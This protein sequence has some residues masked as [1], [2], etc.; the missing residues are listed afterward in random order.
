MAS[1]RAGSPSGPDSTSPI[2]SASPATNALNRFEKK[3]KKQRGV[4]RHQEGL[5]V[6]GQESAA[7]K[8]GAA[9]AAQ[10][11]HYEDDHCG[12]RREIEERRRTIEKRFETPSPTGSERLAHRGQR[13]SHL[14]RGV[15]QRV[16][17][18]AH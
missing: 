10:T 1:S 11:T 3:K 16:E 14:R 15:G 12:E 5:F 17:E 7:L 8:A 2:A 18:E 4:E 9:G 13:L 6:G